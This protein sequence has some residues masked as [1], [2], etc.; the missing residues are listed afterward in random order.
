MIKVAIADDHQLIREGIK[1]VVNDIID[2][3]VQWEAN[4]AFELLDILKD[5][6]PDIGYCNAR[7]KWVGCIE[8]YQRIIS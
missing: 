1:K 3:E 8:R 5:H 2:M 4:D 6:K 7:K